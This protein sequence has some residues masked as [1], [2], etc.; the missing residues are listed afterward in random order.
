MCLEM[1]KDVKESFKSIWRLWSVVEL[2]DKIGNLNNIQSGILMKKHGKITQKCR[3]Q[4]IK[5]LKDIN[6][7]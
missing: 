2:E 5:T 6:M 1:N 4:S 7:L 3:K